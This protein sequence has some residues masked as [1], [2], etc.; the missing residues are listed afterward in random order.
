[1]PETDLRTTAAS[2]EGLQITTC[3]EPGCRAPAE[4]Y[5]RADLADSTGTLMP[6]ARIL[7]L[8][9][10][11]FCMPTDRLPSLVIPTAAGAAG[12]PDPGAGRQEPQPQA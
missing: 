4:V 9:R 2:A 10:H 12:R 3:P 11:F 6:H 7:C 8:S 1:M 5:A